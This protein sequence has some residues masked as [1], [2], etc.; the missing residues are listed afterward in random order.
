MADSD[1]GKG[2]NGSKKPKKR[3]VSLPAL[4]GPW[5]GMVAIG[6][7]LVLAVVDLF[8]PHWAATA[9][10]PAPRWLVD[11]LGCLGVC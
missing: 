10:D 1:D 2:K 3:G 6:C 8:Y 4:I 11:F 5:V 9:E 7:V